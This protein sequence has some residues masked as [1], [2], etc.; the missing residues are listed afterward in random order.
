MVFS[1]LAATGAEF[2]SKAQLRD[3]INDVTDVGGSWERPT[4]YKD[5][6]SFDQ[7]KLVPAA[8]LGGTK[9]CASIACHNGNS[10]TWTPPVGD[11]TKCHTALPQ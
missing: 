5:A 2:K 9:S 1:N 10:A 8:Y 4:G 11:C 6:G 3:D 7:A